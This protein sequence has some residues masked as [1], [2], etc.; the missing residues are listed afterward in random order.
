MV[1]WHRG[2]RCPRKRWPGVR[3]PA[4]RFHMTRVDR[5]VDKFIAANGLR[6][7]Y[8][9]SGS[10]DAPPLL[11]LHSITGATPWEWD[12][13]AASL[14]DRFCVLA[15]DQRGHGASTWAPSYAPDRMVQDIAAIVAGLG[16]GPVTI[17]GHSMGAI[18]G[19]LYAATTHRCAA[20]RHRGR[21][22]GVLSSGR[23]SSSP[24]PLMPGGKRRSPH[25]TRP[26]QSGCQRTLWPASRRCG[27]T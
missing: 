20:A 11:I 6:F 19:Y 1:R 21:G 8:R 13:L 2:S 10:P 18:N 27:G 23:R 24:T 9:E 15:V 22:P 7:H 4:C 5:A 3:R 16:L 17:V 25:R 26:W 12:P 14:A